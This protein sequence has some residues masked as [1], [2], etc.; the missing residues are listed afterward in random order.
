MAGMKRKLAAKKIGLNRETLRDLGTVGLRDAAAAGST[1]TLP[2]FCTS[3]APAACT[4][5]FCIH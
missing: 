4:K 1:P 3:T 5:L 2:Q